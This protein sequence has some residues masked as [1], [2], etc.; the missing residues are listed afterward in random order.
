ML[1]IC[2]SSTLVKLKC[3]LLFNL[4]SLMEYLLI[5]TYVKIS[6]K[7]LFLILI[8][9]KHFHLTFERRERLRKSTLN[10]ILVATK[11]KHLLYGSVATIHV[12][13]N[14]ACSCGLS[15]PPFFHLVAQ[16]KSVGITE[17]RQPKE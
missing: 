15:S 5:V 8:E 9:D 11:R 1:A 13:A 12:L 4:W 14:V 7:C 17:D 6:H 2:A 10:I 16:E 3:R